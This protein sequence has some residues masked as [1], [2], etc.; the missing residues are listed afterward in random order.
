[1]SS[2]LEILQKSWNL[3]R[4]HFGLLGG[5][6]SWLLLPY[7]GLVLVGFLPISI[8]ADVIA[9]LFLIAQIVLTVWIIVALTLLIDY[10]FKKPVTKNILPKHFPEHAWKLI[11]PLLFVAAIAALVT[12]GGLVL[13]I[14]P[15]LIFAIWFSF[16]QLSVILEGKRG[17]KALYYSR[18][19]VRGRFW[20][21]A[22][23]V[24]AGPIVI[25]LIYFFVTTVVVLLIAG[26]TGSSGF[27]SDIEPP[28]WVDVVGSV[29]EIFTLPLYL[30]Y[31]ILLYEQVKK[32]KRSNS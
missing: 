27:F 31:F 13:L 23:R 4:R 3:Y 16:S 1:M 7:V 20:P 5:Y 12:V 25:S 24:V 21:V 29:I 22:W 26:I 8:T 18:E 9:G 30:I 19:L 2:V 17:I 32:T 11:V 10:L 14:V 15:G 6:V 28:L